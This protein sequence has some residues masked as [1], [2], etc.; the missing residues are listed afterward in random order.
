MER[1]CHDCDLV[2]EGAFLTSGARDQ[3]GWGKG[4]FVATK[5]REQQALESQVVDMMR[6]QSERKRAE[7]EGK[8]RAA[9]E[10]VA[11]AERAAAPS[12]PPGVI[13]VA[14]DGP[15]PRA[16]AARE[17][18][19]IQV[20]PGVGNV[21]PTGHD[22]WTTVGRGGGSRDVRGGR[23]AFSI[24]GRGP[25]GFGKYGG[26]GYALDGGRGGQ[27]GQSQGYMAAGDPRRHRQQYVTPGGTAYSKV[28]N[29]LRIAGLQEP[30]ARD[31]YM[32]GKGPL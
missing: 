7:R 23:P 9:A 4:H 6:A 5:Y 2:G 28:P 22:G 20:Q 15:G 25:P 12:A 8:A 19:Q 13:V 17:A 14:A 30:V 18:Q 10:A 27:V 31:L 11:E 16:Q 21:F 1:E 24:G 3:H 32:G 29:G 26:G